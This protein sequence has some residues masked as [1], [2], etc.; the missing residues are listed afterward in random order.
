MKIAVFMDESQ[1]VES[2]IKGKY[3]TVFI[4][5]NNEW[6]VEKKFELKDC[7]NFGI[8]GMR[9]YFNSLIHLIPDTKVIVGKEA[10]G[11]PYNIFYS[12]DFSIWEMEGNP[13]DILDYVMMKE[14][15]H[16]ELDK[17]EGKEEHIVKIGEGKYFIDL[18]ELQNSNGITSKQAIIPF[19]KDKKFDKLEI[20]CCHIP[21]WL[22]VEKNNLGFDMEVKEEEK[23]I[24]KVVLNNIK[25][26]RE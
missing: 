11:I 1:E 7:T 9:S 14:I 18:I 10:Y 2:F 3:L 19:L 6:Q 13:Y 16:E 12:N 25:L 24:Y 4:N 26:R 5:D 23:D 8:G 15:Q 22:N 20:K 21:P 17:E